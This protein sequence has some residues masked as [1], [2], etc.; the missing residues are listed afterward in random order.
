[1]CPHAVD[2]LLH[3]SV[4]TV[5]SLHRVRR[6]PRQR[7]VQEHQRLLQTRQEQL[8]QNLPEP[9]ESPQPRPQA[10][11]FG[12]CGRH[13]ASS[14]EQA[15]DLL[16]QTTQCAQLRPAAGDPSQG[17]SLGGREMAP[18]EEVAVLEQ[19][20]DLPHD[21]LLA[22]GGLP[23]R[24]RAGTATRRLGGLG[25]QV[26]A[27]LGHRAEDRLG[28]FLEDV[29]CAELMRHLTEDRGDRLGIQRRAIGRDPLEA[30]AACLEGGLEATEERLDVAV[31]RVVVENLIEEPLEG[32]VVDDREDAKGAVIQL[33]GGNVTREVG[34]RPIEVVGVDPSRRLFPPRPRPSSGS[35]R[36]G[37]TRGALARG[38]SRRSDKAGRLR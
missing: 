15:I 34:Q 29:E 18:D 6:R 26:L 13:P 28:H 12:Q 11:Q 23:C 10:G 8:L 32:S 21:P 9:D 36:R 14:V 31:G 5:P 7:L 1:M 37:R 22:P 25:R 35:L 17:L 19:L 16:H 30:Q 38:S 4:S 3:L 20:T 2:R 24:L 33:V 27:E